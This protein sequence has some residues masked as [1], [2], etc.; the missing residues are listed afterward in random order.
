LYIVIEFYDINNNYIPVLVEETKTFD[1]GNLQTIR[2]QLRLVASSTGFQFDSGSNPVPPTI[3]TIEEQ[4]T[5]L[6]GSVHYTSQSFDFF[7]NDLSASGAYTSSGAQFPGLL[8][9]IGT[10]NVF[11]TVSNFTGSRSDINVQLVK[12]T[13]ECEGF[14]DTI[15]IYKIL[16]GFGGVNHIIRPYRGTQIRNSSTASLEIQAV[17]IDGINDIILSKQALKN[18]SDIQLHILSRSK[19]YEI[20]PNLEPDK[21]VNLSYV[22][23]SGMFYGLTTG[24]LGS[25]QID[26][27]AVFDRDSIDFRRTIFLIPSSSNAGKF[28]Y[29]VSSSVLASIILEDLQD[30]LDSGVVIYN[31]DIIHNKS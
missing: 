6:T 22:T 20:N 12:L 25:K 1:G 23:A 14:T 2:K 27:N 26:Y 7:G 18:Y 8:N 31:A 24:S 29:E 9:G 28:A 11:M 19:N 10:S 15:N 4:K 17:R 16:D 5:L 13:G 3:I 30:G 21:F